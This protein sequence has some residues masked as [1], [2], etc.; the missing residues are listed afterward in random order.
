MLVAGTGPQ[1]LTKT[2]LIGTDLTAAGKMTV[3]M[4][5]IADALTRNLCA[6]SQKGVSAVT[7]TLLLTNE[8][9]GTR[10]AS[11]RLGRRMTNM[12]PQEVAGWYSV[13][14]WC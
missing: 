12:M 6:L 8:A 10:T 2:A 5:V 11:Q 4:A 13:C 3:P 9:Q 7:K 1:S 14:L